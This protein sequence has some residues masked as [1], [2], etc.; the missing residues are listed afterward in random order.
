MR[1]NLNVDSV[2]S[3]KN[4]FDEVIEVF[5]DGTKDTEKIKP[6]LFSRNQYSF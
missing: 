4:A 2:D 6:A 5:K 3:L 1:K